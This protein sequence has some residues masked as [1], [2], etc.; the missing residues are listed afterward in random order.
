LPKRAIILASSLGLA[1]LALLSYGAAGQ[2][3]S[4]GDRVHVA[5]YYFPAWHSD[6]LRFPGDSGEWPALKNAK[7]RFAGQQ[8][9]K[10]P[11]WGYQ[12]ESDPAVMAQK[13]EAAVDN[14]VSVFLFD[15]YRHDRGS[16]KGPALESALNDGFLKAKNRSKMKFALMWANHET[17]DSPGPITR[18][19]FETMT[20][21]IVSD[22][23]SS[24]SY[25]T[26][27]GRCYFS[28]Y[29]LTNLI[30]GLGGIEQ[31]RE[32]LDSFRKK[33]IAA[34]HRGLFLNVID[35]GIPKG[36][37][38][39]LK[40]LGADSVTSYVWVHKIHLDSFPK[41]DYQLTGN[42][43][44]EYWDTHKNDYGIPYFP[45][46]TTGWDPTPRVPA[47]KPYDGKSGYP[48][49]PV[50]WD[51]SVGKFRSALEAAKTRAL[52]LPPGQ[53]VVTIYAWNEWTEG[54]YLEPDTVDKMSYLNAVRDVFPSQS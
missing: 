41:T 28:V 21:H 17:A 9:P 26:I 50:L 25:W 3:A 44:F 15:W 1:A 42:R 51:N 33:T 16:W 49:T 39:L 34:G 48:N 11:L 54:G 30:E 47:S 22:F 43:Y 36:S 5:A 2:N 13:I 45:N 18:E 24:S 46:V 6:P 8:Q 38:D 37:P 31:T 19:G 12:N 10:V 40:Q 27:D 53:R 29:L 35:F 20:D 52:T 14:G 23:F 4:N 32:A 7:P